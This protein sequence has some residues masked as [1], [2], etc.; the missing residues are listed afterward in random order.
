MKK[1]FWQLCNLLNKYIAHPRMILG[2]VRQFD[3]VYLPLTRISN[4]TNV[5]YPKNLQIADNVFVWH[6]SI[7]E[8]S[9]GI[10]IDEGCQIGAYVLMASHSSHLAIRLYGKHF[11]EHN[12]NHKGYI[13]GSI[14]IGK[15]TFVGP[16]SVIMP[17]TK[18]GKGS[19]VSAYSLVKGEFPDFAII[20]GNPAVV[21][22]DTREIDNKQLAKYPE[23]QGYYDEWSK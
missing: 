18:I 3:G 8:C 20:A 1:L 10:T 13:R 9:N 7:L 22:G 23:L 14:E 2:Y 4:T 11:I 5:I 21:V 6:H 12:G 19:I 16:H 17:G 15:Y